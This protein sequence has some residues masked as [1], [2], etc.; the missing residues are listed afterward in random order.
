MGIVVTKKVA[1]RYFELISGGKDKLDVSMLLDNG[2]SD[3]K[4]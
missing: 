3:V 1:K 2:K 4:R